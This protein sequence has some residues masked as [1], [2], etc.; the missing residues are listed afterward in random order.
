LIF[1]RKRR[2]S[3][4]PT[5]KEESNLRLR[6]LVR[7]RP[8]DNVL[9]IAICKIVPDCPRSSLL[10]VG[11]TDKRP[12]CNYGI[13]SFEQHRD[14]RARGHELYQ[15]RIEGLS[16]VHCIEFSSSLWG[17]TNHLHR[18]DVKACLFDSAD[19]FSDELLPDTIWFQDGQCSI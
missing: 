14:T 6:G 16:S 4:Y 17:Q 13:I 1:I 12:E 19:Y 11:C 10:R 2:F 5:F 9:L 18:A 15:A 7:I 8:V 3:H